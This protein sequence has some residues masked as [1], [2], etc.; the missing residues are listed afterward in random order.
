[1]PASRLPSGPSA[2]AT[3]RITHI[4]CS[5]RAGGAER[6]A[7]D[8]SCGLAA[9]GHA[10]RFVVIDRLSGDAA[11]ESKVRELAAAGIEVVNLGRTV[12]S[13]I[14]GLWA[15]CS[16]FA[17]V[18]RESSCDVVHSHLPYAHAVAAVAR[19]H[20]GSTA[21]QLLTVHTSREHWTSWQQVLIGTQAIA[22]CSRAALRGSRHPRSRTWIAPNGVRREGFAIRRP[23]SDPLERLGLPA[24]RR[25]IISVGSLLPGKNHRT[26]IEAMAVLRTDHDV[27]LIICGAGDQAHL[28]AVVRRL[29]LDDRVSLLGPRTDVPALLASSDLFLSASHFEGMPIAVLEAMTSGLPAVLSPIEAHE[30]VTEGIPGCL[31]A[32]ENLPGP[33]AQACATLLRRKLDRDVLQAARTEPLSAFDI[34]RCA[35]NYESIYADLEG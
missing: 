32:A 5:L 10:I 9:R 16:R 29:W 4:I 25:R 17:A 26:S 18:L 19:R 33:I 3:M 28:L 8:L 11:E 27:H 35:Q 1:M 15:S 7:V 12:G 34:V 21:R 30:D 13:N 2:V 22:Y 23:D 31:I 24:G 20:S 6:M 14:A